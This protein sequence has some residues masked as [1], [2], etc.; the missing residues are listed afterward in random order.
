VDTDASAQRV[1]RAYL[2]D[3]LV[4]RDRAAEAMQIYSEAPPLAPGAAADEAWLR[5]EGA[6]ADAEAA[7]DRE[8]DSL[9]RL[10][11]ACAVASAQLGDLHPLTLDLGVRRADLTGSL[12]RYDDAYAQLKPLLAQ[13]E[14]VFGAQHP[15]TLTPRLLIGEFHLAREEFPLALTILGQVSEQAQFLYGETYPLSLYARGQWISALAGVGRLGEAITDQRKVL[16][17]RE[18]HYGNAHNDTRVAL[19]NLAV[20]LDNNGQHEESLRM[21]EELLRRD[22]EAEGPAGINTLQHAYNL[23]RTYW[24]QHRYA[25]SHRIL[26]PALAAAREIGRAH[27]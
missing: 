22:G 24:E 21:L 1:A 16:A 17:L 5:L 10:E 18:L 7:A 4:D 20:L 13:F 12:G 14:K 15:R 27:V 23:G 19:N 11:K 2:I 9:A 3:V 26:G 25:D 8:S 6:M